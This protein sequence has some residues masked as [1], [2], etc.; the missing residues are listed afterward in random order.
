MTHNRSMGLLKK[1]FGDANKEKADEPDSSIPPSSHFHESDTTQNLEGRNA[2]R[3]EVVQVI[4]RDVMR[5]HG[6][7]SDWIDCRILSTVSKSGRYGMHVNFIVRQA[8]DKLL[9]YIFAFQDSFSREL[10]RFE[11]R[12][13]DW[14]LSLG[15]QFEGDVPTRSGL[16]EP[17]SWQ[18][19]SAGAATVP[20]GLDG[21]RG[22]AATDDSKTDE[23]VQRDLEALFAIRDAALAQNT[24]DHQPDFEPTR[25]GFDEPDMPRR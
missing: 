15:W 9:H 24:R 17:S 11:P 18:N 13:K 22:F 7:P 12:S 6:I 10:L 1:F 16:P 21:D 5:K 8:H 25:P 19:T 14:L 3:R 23:D 2:P 20:A 4:L